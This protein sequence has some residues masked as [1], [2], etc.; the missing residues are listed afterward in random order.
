MVRKRGHG[1]RGQATVE[2]AVVL[3]IVIVVAVIVVN[4]LTFL[5]SCATFD[6]VARQAVCAWG[7]AP[8]AGQSSQEV[9]ALVKEEVERAVGAPHV[10]VAVRA[11]G[12]GAGLVRY[13]ARMEYLP[14]LFGLGL[15]REIFGVALP[16][17]VHEVSM[18]V[19][20]Y[21]PGVLF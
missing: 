8:E 7:A 1:E 19:E 21:R 11:E 12:A 4:A 13:T 3:P 15:R 18:T 10:T 6:R 5:G 9:A 17:L 14:T 16:P 20:A 2:L